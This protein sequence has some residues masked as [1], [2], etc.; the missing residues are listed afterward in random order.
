[1]KRPQSSLSSFFLPLSLLL[2]LGFIW[3]SAYTIAGVA[4]V[5]NV[6]PLGYAF[7][8]SVGPA[9]LTSLLCYFSGLRVPF[10]IPYIRF[11]FICGL[12]GIAIPNT[13]MY[14]VVAKYLP[15]GITAVLVNTTP[16]MTYLLA[17]FFHQERFNLT[18]FFGV[19][20]TILG[21]LSF[22][23]MTNDITYQGDIKWLLIIL[24]SPLCFSIASLYASRFRPENSHSLSVSAGML[25]FS[26]LLLTPV[27][28]GTHTFYPISSPFSIADW[29]IVIEIL[30]SGL[31][32]ILL[33]QLLK[34]SGAVYYSMVSGVVILTGL[35]W[36]W[37]IFNETLS[38]RL[39]IAV[40]FIL[41]GI[42]WVTRR[43]ST[44]SK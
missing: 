20:L 10:S 21:I 2:S 43:N 38:F 16:V 34:L 25:I 1:M 8:Q 33:F 11:Y 23:F 13:I 37:L 29:V 39:W 32:Y 42:I 6:P 44:C 36:G 40:S 30:L 26:S 28:I 31:S 22:S 5:N 27:V 12:F 41:I 19:F 24:I 14:Y 7:W 9:I 3:G 15:A 4:M 17:L 35:F 18:R